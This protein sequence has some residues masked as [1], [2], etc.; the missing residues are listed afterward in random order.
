MKNKWNWYK[1]GFVFSNL[2]VFDY[3]QVVDRHTLHPQHLDG[4]WSGLPALL[5]I[6]ASINVAAPSGPVNTL[7]D[8]TSHITAT[9]LPHQLPPPP[10]IQDCLNKFS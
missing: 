9:P 10:L 1:Y 4:I 7:C 5:A 6:L 8:D 2:G 3:I